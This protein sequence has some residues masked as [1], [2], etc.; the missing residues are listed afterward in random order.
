MGSERERHGTPGTRTPLTLYQFAHVAPRR[1][2]RMDNSREAQVLSVAR[3]A[4]SAQFL[5]RLRQHSGNLMYEQHHA[6][7]TSLLLNGLTYMTAYG[8]VIIDFDDLVDRDNSAWA[9]PLAQVTGLDAGALL[10]ARDARVSEKT[11]TSIPL[12]IEDPTL[13]RLYQIAHTHRNTAFC[14]PLPGSS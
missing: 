4:A 8:G 2:S 10:H 12:L 9:E 7:Y 1:R 11:R 3:Q 14:K 5:A 13:E 6:A